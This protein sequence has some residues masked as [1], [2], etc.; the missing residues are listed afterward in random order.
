MPS[1]SAVYNTYLPVGASIKSDKPPDADIA[2]LT[3]RGIAEEALTVL[4]LVRRVV[5]PL[6]RDLERRKILKSYSFLVHDRTSGVPCPAED[7]SSYIHLRLVVTQVDVK[8]FLP[9]G[10]IYT[11]RVRPS[12][13]EARAHEV[14]D[15]QAAW[16]LRLIEREKN[17]S[18]VDLLGVV[19][20]NLHY[21]ANMAQM[22]IY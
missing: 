5:L 6:V 2:W 10:L 12:K 16:Y 14:I 9:K 8:K 7:V 22:R 4:G 19:R 13:D 15:A 11:T 18:D 1:R 17:L 3:S 20:Q 21:F